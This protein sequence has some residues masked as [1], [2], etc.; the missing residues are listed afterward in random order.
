MISLLTKFPWQA[1][2]Y[3]TMSTR[4]KIFDA[5]LKMLHLLSMNLRRSP[6]SLNNSMENS[7]VAM[8]GPFSNYTVPTM[9]GYNTPAGG[10]YHNVLPRS[11]GGSRP[12]NPML[13]KDLLSAALNASGFSE[14]QRFELNIVVDPAYRCFLLSPLAKSWPFEVLG[15]RRGIEEDVVEVSLLTLLFQI[16]KS[17]KTH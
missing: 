14:K 3:Y 17:K 5:A 15:R 9:S 11:G 8:Q 2:S 6:N 4:N 13:L 7:P 16:E 12:L 1:T 10:G